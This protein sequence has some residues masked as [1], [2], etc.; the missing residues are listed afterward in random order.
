M[1]LRQS[2]ALPV[3]QL[4][5]CA[6]LCSFHKRDS[7][8][9]RHLL[10]VSLEHCDAHLFQAVEIRQYLVMLP[11]GDWGVQHQTHQLIWFGEVK[12]VFQTKFRLRLDSDHALEEVCERQER[13][14]FVIENIPN[15]VEL[16]VNQ[17]ASLQRADR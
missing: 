12:F 8:R 5:N 10:V 4:V 1:Q 9:S 6:G 13:L 7:L 2:L 16:F 17:L 3:V 15:L 14:A 11:C